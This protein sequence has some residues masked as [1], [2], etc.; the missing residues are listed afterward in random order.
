MAS[1]QGW[2]RVENLT[3]ALQDQKTMNIIPW[4]VAVLAKFPDSQTNFRA[5][6][7]WSLVQAGKS[8]GLGWLMEISASEVGDSQVSSEPIVEDDPKQ[9]DMGENPGSSR[10]EPS[11]LNSVGIRKLNLARRYWIRR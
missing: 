1:L 11:E 6:M 4:A 3:Y 2:K 7:I 9:Q 5:S 10:P 8:M